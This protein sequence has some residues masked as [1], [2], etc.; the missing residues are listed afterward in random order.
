MFVHPFQ[1]HVAIPE[2]GD[3]MAIVCSLMRLLSRGTVKLKST[4]VMDQPEINF[5]FFSEEAD[6]VATQEGE[7][8]TV[9]DV[10][11]HGEGMR[12]VTHEPYPEHLDDLKKDVKP[13]GSFFSR[14]V[15]PSTTHAVRVALVLSR[16]ISRVWWMS[17]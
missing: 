5:N 6:L 2:S 17:G 8:F 10:V 1:P 16:V 11:Q 7:R 3:Y 14:D 15:L 13:R 12:D 9:R 4:D